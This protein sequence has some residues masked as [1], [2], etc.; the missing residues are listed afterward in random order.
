MLLLLSNNLIPVEILMVMY[1]LSGCNG[2]VVVNEVGVICDVDFVMVC[3]D[4]LLYGLPNFC[5]CLCFRRNQVGQ[6]KTV[7]ADDSFTRVVG[8]RTH[9]NTR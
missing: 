4:V 2:R 7:R 8:N 3:V 5:L 6:L 9:K 1:V